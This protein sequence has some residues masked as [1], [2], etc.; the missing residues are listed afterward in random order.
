[1]LTTWEQFVFLC[2]CLHF[3][4]RI[5]E[6][7][8]STTMSFFLVHK[9]MLG[10]IQ[11]KLN[12]SRVSISVQGAMKGNKSLYTIFLFCSRPVLRRQHNKNIMVSQ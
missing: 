8:Q 12:L 2:H 5:Q 7:F 9:Y 10:K 3:T 4:M 6:H 1:M 11:L